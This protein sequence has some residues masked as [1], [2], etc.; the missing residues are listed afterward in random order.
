MEPRGGM[1]DRGNMQF[2]VAKD[3]WCEFN[4]RNAYMVHVIN[5]IRFKMAYHILQIM[6]I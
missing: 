4:I 2:C 3:H 5:K 1:A 6:I